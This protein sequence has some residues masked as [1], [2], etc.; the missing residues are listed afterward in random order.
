[1]SK[2]K[3]RIMGACIVLLALCCCVAIGCSSTSTSSSAAASSSAASS[4]SASAAS[5]EAASSDSSSGASFSGQ[6]ELVS[7]ASSDDFDRAVVGTWRIYS[8]N[9]DGA[10]EDTK[11]NRNETALLRRYGLKV[12]LVLFS[13][14]TAQLKVGNDLD[15]GTW[16]ETG[17]NEMEL[18]LDDY[19]EIYTLKLASNR[20]TLNDSDGTEIVFTRV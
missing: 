10:R 14:H 5:S 16:K 18:S 7:S 20:L 6:S 8:A 3:K 12:N 1:M 2:M 4:A 17:N 11:I 19:D 13:D 9:I 15:K